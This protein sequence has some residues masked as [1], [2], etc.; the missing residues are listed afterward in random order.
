MSSSRGGRGGIFASKSILPLLFLLCSVCL[1]AYFFSICSVL[2]S[3][4]ASDTFSFLLPFEYEAGGGG[5]LWRRLQLLQ[6]DKEMMPGFF[7][8]LL[9]WT[10]P[11]TLTTLSDRMVLMMP[12]FFRPLSSNFCPRQR[13]TKFCYFFAAAASLLSLLI[14]V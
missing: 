5:G 6:M 4:S 14:T 1:L 13:E 7:S 8:I 3:P 2:V 11:C 9:S 12:F 10:A